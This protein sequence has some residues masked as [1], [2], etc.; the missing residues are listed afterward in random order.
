MTMVALIFQVVVC[1][2]SINFYEAG[3]TM[4]QKNMVNE[5]KFCRIAYFSRIIRNTRINK[6]IRV[7]GQGK[8]AYY[9]TLGTIGAA[10]RHPLICLLL[11]F[12]SLSSASPTFSPVCQCSE[13]IDVR[14][15]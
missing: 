5:H 11:F 14:M 7:L 1:F 10:P 4:G 13:V 3:I 15:R 2:F 6:P 9:P 12:S 8:M